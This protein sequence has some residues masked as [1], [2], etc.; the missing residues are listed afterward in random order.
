MAAALAGLRANEARYFKGKYG[1]DFRVEPA[2]EADLEQG[3]V[4]GMLGEEQ[5]LTFARLLR[6]FLR[7]DPDIILVGEVRDLETA[8]KQSAEFENTY[9]GKLA[10][11][12]AEPGAPGFVEAVKAYATVGE[13]SDRLRAI[14]GEHRELI[15]I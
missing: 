10:A 15:T 7:Q 13:V 6:S 11:L 12:A 14:W 2:A 5:E 1:H 4:G 9:K 8:E 3:D